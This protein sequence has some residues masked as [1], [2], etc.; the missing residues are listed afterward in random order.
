[1]S[2]KHK[3]NNKSVRRPFQLASQNGK[4]HIPRDGGDSSRVPIGT[5][6]GGTC[7]AFRS[8]GGLLLIK[9]WRYPILMVW[10][11]QHI[12]LYTHVLQLAGSQA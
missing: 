12:I 6:R 3:R 9:I 5:E 10:P 7:T 2:S 8:I 1:M 11:A 4:G